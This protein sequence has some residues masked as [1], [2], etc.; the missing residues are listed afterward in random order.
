MTRSAPLQRNNCWSGPCPSWVC[1]LT[2]PYLLTYFSSILQHHF[3]TY[4][5]LVNTG[6]PGLLFLRLFNK[7]LAT[8][9]ISKGT[10]DPTKTLL[11]ILPNQFASS[12]TNIV[13]NQMQLGLQVKIFSQLKLIR[14]IT[15]L[16][17]SW[18]TTTCRG[19]PLI[20]NNKASQWLCSTSTLCYR[21]ISRKG[22]LKRILIFSPKC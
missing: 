16:G 6:L 4:L 2:P 20:T 19:S 11:P 1:N 8:V 13:F 15:S 14:S 12:K 7:F 21:R 3:L 17:E 5:F 18:V 10:G 9:T 22:D